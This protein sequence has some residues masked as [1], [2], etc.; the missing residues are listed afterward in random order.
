MPEA[1]VNEDNGSE[2][3]QN[4]VRFAQQSFIVNSESET[5]GE[6]KLPHEQFRFRINGPDAPHIE[7]ARFFIVYVHSGLKIRFLRYGYVI[8]SFQLS[9]HSSSDSPTTVR[10]PFST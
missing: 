5:F 2:F 3:R 10:P 9:T 1:T 4:Y 6:K 8:F 7:A